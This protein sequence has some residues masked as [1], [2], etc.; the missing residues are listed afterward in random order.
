MRAIIL[1][2]GNNSV[3]DGLI[4][5]L[6]IEG[7]R[8]L[9][10][11][12]SCLRNVGAE[13]VT[14]IH[15]EKM[16]EIGRSDLLVR[17]TQKDSFGGAISSL[18]EVAD[19]FNGEDDVIVTYGDTIYDTDL[20]RTLLKS[21]L[22]YGAACYL[23]RSG[24]DIGSYREYAV[25]DDGQLHHISETTDIHGVRTV[26]TGLL[27]IKKEKAQAIRN[28]LD[29]GILDERKH[30]G[31]LLNKM[32]EMGVDISPVI[33][34]KG[35][36]EITSN[37]HYEKVLSET[38][39]L[40]NVIQIHTDWTKRAQKYDRLDWVNN[41]S[42]LRSIV[43]IA[44]RRNPRNI[45]DVGTGTGKVIKALRDMCDAEEYWGIDYSQAMLD[46]MENTDGLKLICCDA[47]TLEGIPE[48]YF[49]LVTA[50]MVFHHINDIEKALKS[51]KR[52]LRS[53]GHFII[54]E[55]VPPSI[56]TVDWY[57]EMFR[58]KEDRKTLTE[59]DLIQYMLMAGFENVQT[60]TV[61]IKDASLNNW[62]DNSGIPQKNIDIIKK[63]HFEA[64]DFVKEDYSM[65]FLNNDCLM[66]WRF[67]VTYGSVQV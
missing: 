1:A 47:E 28:Y 49:D 16:S 27:Y 14:L 38:Q 46:K 65:K 52:V 31:E 19:L 34:E 7:E 35:W 24:E 43:E 21:P 32:I 18:Q 41:D 20:L 2:G 12:I 30:L 3:T 51:I 42:L 11:Q 29:S 23:D 61:T 53:G 4:S 44:M 22:P 57:T 15:S 54:C 33:I 56:R 26:F 62:L 64:P 39:L 55:G 66:N 50:R 37:K 5:N 6:E 13:E 63:M 40:Q 36:A 58:F 45:L 60:T 9:D 25:V 48:N 59:V 17:Y 67:A 10:I 8:L